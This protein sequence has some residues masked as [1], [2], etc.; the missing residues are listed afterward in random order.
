MLKNYLRI[1][2]RH[3]AKNKGYSF[4]N[5]AG[6]ASGLAITLLIALWI[7]DEVTFNH[8]HVNHKRIVQGMV[9]QRLP[10]RTWNGDVVS[11]AFGKA[12]RDK[13]QDVFPL[14]AS[15]CDGDFHLVASGDKKLNART[16]WSQKELTDIFTFKMLSGSN[17]SF[18]DPS[19]TLIS[20]SLATAL[21]GKEDPVGKTIRYQN[22]LDFRIGG[23][24][25]DQPHNSEF[26][27]IQVLLPWYNKE[28]SYHINSNNWGD[29]NG[30]TYS[31]LAPN[32][33]AEQASKRIE[34]L[35]TGEI[36]EWREDAMVYP[37]DR[38]YLHNNFENGLPSGG[39]IQ[40][41]WL[42]GIIGVFVLL[43][44][45][46]NFMNLSTARSEKRAREVGI[47][48]TVGSLKK[49]LVIQ[50][51]LESTLLALLAFVVS[52]VLVSIALPFFNQLAAKTVSIPW[53]NP[54][55]WLSALVFTVITGVIAGS[56]PAFYLSKF[57]PVKV[58]K[59]T[60]RI[61]RFA[62]LPRQVLVVLQFSVSLT[63]IIGT[64]IV[65]RQIQFAQERPIGYHRDGLVTVA[66]NTPDLY[67]HID[68][69]RQELLQKKLV[70]SVAY[71]SMKVT[72]FDNN[73]DLEWRGKRPDQGSVWF[74]N[75]NVSRDFGRTVGWQ[76]AQ[77]RDFS[78][79]YPT[80][81][82][83]MILNEASV[84]AVGIPNPIG[85]IMKFDGKSYHVIGVVKDMITQSPYRTVEPAIFLGDGYFATITMR[86]PQDKSISASLDALRPVF[87]RY[88]PGSPFM[89][90]F[91]D[92][93]YARKF[94]GE[95]RVGRLAM[96]FTSLAIF[97]SCLGLFGLASFVAEQRTKE[98]GVRKVLG[99][100][101]FTLWGL[102]SKSFVRLVVL[103]FFISMPLAHF[104]MQKWL[105]QY[106]LR[107]PM[108]WWI[109]AASGAGI[110][111]VTIL[112]VSYQSLKAATMNPVKSLRS[113]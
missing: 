107:T 4:I 61:G 28:N 102:L 39:R 93:D 35:P 30:R 7:Q 63:L 67:N 22:K 71:S 37:L 59:G 32:I 10:E 81:S 42:F 64:L 1:A 46:I 69:L 15:I 47:R 13:Y 9:I 25:E 20:Q 34:H 33:N 98:I 26:A 78:Y 66:V 3:L 52:L 62:S 21:F 75:V 18:A 80:D 110:L 88:N 85:E 49:Q 12:I 6:L 44:A 92:E 56:Y 60:F 51:L 38:A 103:S 77:G 36:K 24:Y 74:R 111:I 106:A 113:E 96:V 29:H 95:V 97:I 41:V 70:A 112:T 86:L 72:N 8:Y 40:Y 19:T 45:C 11:M 2:F 109:Y 65:Y 14:T 58:L 101:V 48:K 90:E 5:I 17:A 54:V 16:L 84:K 108:S 23:V 50:F 91:S 89:Y 43:L 31:L 83:A 55:F 100:N 53:S 76:I 94:E 104:A 105:E 82:S 87:N 27:D 73:N 57:D 99:A 68:A 79:D